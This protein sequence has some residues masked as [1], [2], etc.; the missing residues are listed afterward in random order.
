M[1]WLD[2]LTGGFKKTADRLGENISGL[3]I[4][5]CARYRDPRRY[6]GG[7]DRVRPRPRGVEANP[8][9][10]RR[11]ALRAIGRARPA[12]HP[13]RGDRGDSRTRRETARRVGLPAAP[14]HPGDRGQRQR[15]DHHHRQARPFADGTGLWRAAGGG[16][17]VPRGGDRAVAD[18]GPTNWRGGDFGQGRRRCG[19]NRVRRRETG[20]RDRDRRVDRRHGRTIAEQDPSDGRTDQGAQSARAAEPGSA[21][22]RHCWCSTRPPG[23]MRST[24]STYS[25]AVPG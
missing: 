20:D 11:A 7:A 4:E 19:R 15:Q 2:R 21:A 9:C 18:L 13:G 3:A 1:S 14:R 12:H 6:R 17:H 16:R 25:G 23:R 5:G 8:Q 22:R 10:D 24:R